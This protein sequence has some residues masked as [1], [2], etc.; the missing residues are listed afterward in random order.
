[1]VGSLSSFTHSVTATPLDAGIPW[2]S[3]FAGIGGLATAGA[4]L[5]SLVVL[6]QQIRTQQQ[7]QQD[8]HRDHAS[9]IS[10]WLTLGHEPLPAGVEVWFEAPNIKI[11]LH[12]VNT[13]DRPAMAAMAMVGVRS[14]VWR[15][16]GTAAQEALEERAAE[17]TTVA[18][19]PS[20]KLDV[21]LK[22]DVPESVADIV[23]EYGAD[24]LIG[25]LLFTDAAGVNWVRTHS[26]RLIER[27]SA[28]WADNIYLSLAGRDE[29]RRRLLDPKSSRISLRRNKRPS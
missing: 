8:R 12:M 20:E 15:D 13:S 17:W 24:A 5:V 1:M 21:P 11:Q 10:F 28:E 25:E 27:S 14:D 6:W 26:G 19:A 18:I 23:G 4:L 9:H 29:R 22:F 3:I 7:A 16:A 2:T